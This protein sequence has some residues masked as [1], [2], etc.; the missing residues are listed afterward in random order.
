MTERVAES[1]RKRK[2][3]GRERGGRRE[4]SEW[5]E[6]GRQTDGPTEEEEVENME[7][8]HGSEQTQP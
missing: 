8:E 7:E 1:C 2:K 6:G 4:S 3:E 5:R